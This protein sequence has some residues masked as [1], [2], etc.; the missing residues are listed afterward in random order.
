MSPET[1]EPKSFSRAWAVGL[2]TVREKAIS[3]LE[4]LTLI[5]NLTASFYALSCPNLKTDIEIILQIG[6][7]RLLADGEVKTARAGFDRLVGAY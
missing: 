2:L 5:P 1:L 4:H 7:S 3:S 6:L